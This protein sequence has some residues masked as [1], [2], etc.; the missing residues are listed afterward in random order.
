MKSSL[1]TKLLIS[2]TTIVSSSFITIKTPATLA[3]TVAKDKQS[4]KQD[5]QYRCID[6]NGTP[7][8]VAYTRR[9]PIELILWNSNYF[10][11]SGYTPERRCQEVTARFQQHSD[12]KNLRYISTGVMN[13][14][15][16]ICVSEKSGNCKPDGLLITL[17][18]DD[19]AQQ[20]FKDLFDL[21]NRK[22]AGGI[23][24]PAMPGIEI[25]EVINVDN[26]LDQSPLME[27]N[28]ILSDTAP[29]ANFT[30]KNSS[31]ETVIENPFDNF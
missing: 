3:Q 31:E 26:F 19:N 1:I 8:T 13:K 14:Y 29:E 30:N 23:Y 28:A 10:S 25:K 15:Q 27:E 11:G 24:R 17:Q 9:G 7:A 21:A 16:V 20:V 12:A 2:I 22:V 6:R 4:T 5:V 18:N